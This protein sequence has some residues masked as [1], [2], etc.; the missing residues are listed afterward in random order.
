MDDYTDDP[1]HKVTLK[2]IWDREAKQKEQVAKERWEKRKK[3][4][5]DKKTEFEVNPESQSNL[6]S[7]P[8]KK[9][10]E[11]QTKR[12]NDRKQK[13]NQNQKQKQKQPSPQ[14]KTAMKEETGK[15]KNDPPK[16]K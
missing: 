16:S 7:V 15:Y 8:N 13:Q 3:F 6:E 14:S 4:L 1:A 9:A 10:P 12:K 5:S 11:T 2:Q